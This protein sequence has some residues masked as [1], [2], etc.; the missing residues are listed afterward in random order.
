MCIRR[1]ADPITYGDYSKSMR[2]LVGNRL[3]KF[4]KA[5]S[6]ML[7]GSIDFLGVNYYTTNYAA[8]SLSNTVNI[9]YTTDMHATLTSKL[10]NYYLKRLSYG[11]YLL[12]T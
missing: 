2:S 9:T 7:K 11:F 5:Q 1:Y 10:Y 6:M 4:T 12:L 3:P 8:Y